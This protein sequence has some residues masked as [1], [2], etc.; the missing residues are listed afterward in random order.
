MPKTRVFLSAYFIDALK[1]LRKKYPAVVTEVK[2]L[3]LRLESGDFEGDKIQGIG[4]DAYKVRLPN[5][6]A[7]RGKRGGFRV[8]YFVRMSDQVILLIV[9]SKSERTD[10]SLTAVRQLIQDAIDE[11]SEP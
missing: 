6:S 11:F 1:R 2:S 8:I 9:Y 3:V 7:N 5:P 10:V 4:F